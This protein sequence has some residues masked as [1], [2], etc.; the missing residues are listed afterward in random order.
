MKR[1][2]LYLLMAPLVI[3]MV[4]FLILPY[5]N[6][7]LQS[8]YS[9]DDFGVLKPGF[10]LESYSRFFSGKLYYVT[11]L[12]TFALSAVVTV[13]TLLLSI[14]LAYYIAFKAK[15]NKVFLYTLIIL[16]LWVSYIVRAYAWKIVLGETGVLNSFLQYVGLTDGPISSLLYSDIAVVI[17]M[18]HIYTPFV[19]MPVYTAF[20]Q[21][22]R[23]L[24]EAS[25]D[26]GANRW[27]TFRKVVFPLSLPGVIAGGTFAFVLSLGDFLAP[28]LL[29]GP[30]T[31][32]IAN[33]F[34]NMF[35]TSNDKPLGSAIGIV[36]LIVVIA[37]LELSSKAEKKF[38]S[39][40]SSRN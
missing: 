20:E 25:K 18:T 24:V 38:S 26:L 14:P 6:V 30:N 13:C 12:K 17:A 34:Q 10:T 36:L 4:A 32:F 3:W 23:S 11:L 40:E 5:V 21:I 7:L 39:L 35:G 27:N 15:R 31:L 8:F 37:V 1:K 16:P 2:G 28:V 19:L 22:P 29:G 33:I 9:T